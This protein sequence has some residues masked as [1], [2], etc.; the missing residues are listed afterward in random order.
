MKK[1]FFSDND[2]SILIDTIIIKNSYYTNQK[3]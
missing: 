1:S 2:N 3:L